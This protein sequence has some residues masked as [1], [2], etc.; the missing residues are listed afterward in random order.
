M[1]DGHDWVSVH[2]FSHAGTGPLVADVVAPALRQWRTSRRVRGSFYLSHWEGGP[3]VRVRLLPTHPED[4]GRLEHELTGALQQHLAGRPAQG[5]PPEHY[6]LLVE[7]GQTL[8][9]VSDVSPLLPDGTVISWAYQPEW[10]RFGGTARADSVV[11][12]FG[13]SS[14]VAGAVHEAG[15][16]APRRVSLAL[17]GAL[18]TLRRLTP[19]DQVLLDTLSQAAHF[20]SGSL[21]DEQRTLEARMNTL[22]LTEDVSLRRWTAELLTGPEPRVHP[23]ARTMADE[24]C[25]HLNARGPSAAVEALDLLHLHHNRLGFGLRHEARVWLTLLHATHYVLKGERYVH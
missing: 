25:R 22:P 20:W 9:G 23:F 5:L 14:A 7:Q 8:E 12:A 6:R 1:L 2:A 19:S 15:W 13:V 3:H 17:Q 18:T 24:I 16:N 4:A 10:A 21:G 11:Q